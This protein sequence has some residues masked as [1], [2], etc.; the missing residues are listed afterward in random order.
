VPI[1]LPK[2]HCRQS[3]DSLHNGCSRGLTPGEREMKD[4]SLP[5][6][7]LRPTERL[8]LCRRLFEATTYL[9]SSA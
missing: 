7:L 3:S 5:K 4:D 2:Y 6:P 9:F 1:Y 8:R